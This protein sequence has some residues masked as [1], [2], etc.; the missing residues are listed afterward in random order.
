MNIHPERSRIWVTSDHFEALAGKFAGQVGLT[1]KPSPIRT[2]KRAVVTLGAR[3][4]LPLIDR[5]PYDE[6]MLKIH[7]TMKEDA[8]FQANCRKD[9]W[10]FPAGCAWIVFTDGTS[11][12]CLSGQYM[13]EQTFIVRRSGLVC[14]ELAPI[15]ILERIAG[16]PLARRSA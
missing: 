12:A 10:E 11:H 7:H 15:S 4:G 13:M 3:M 1:G 2:W 9:R 16:H 5:P 6:F 14:P 8:A